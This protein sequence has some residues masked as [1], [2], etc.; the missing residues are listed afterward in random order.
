MT[1]GSD[2]IKFNNWTNKSANQTVSGKSDNTRQLQPLSVQLQLGLGALSS[3][4]N[5]TSATDAVKLEISIL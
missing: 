2:W 5:S 1:L 3:Q 4:H